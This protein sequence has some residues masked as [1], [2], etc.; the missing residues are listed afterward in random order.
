MNKTFVDLLE[1]PVEEIHC[2][3]EWMSGCYFNHF[4]TG[5]KPNDFL[6][7]IDQF[8]IQNMKQKDDNEWMKDQD[9]ITFHVIKNFNYDG[10]RV[11]SLFVVRFDNKVT[12]V[13][14]NAGREGDDHWGNVILDP[15][16]YGDM[17]SYITDDYIVIYQDCVKTLSDD[18]SDFLEFYDQSYFGTFNKYD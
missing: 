1:L 9:R 10:R 6:D 14:K 18:A 7:G 12:M 8:Y 15:V 5:H 16:A 11:W 2:D 17:H 3:L 13:C 4:H